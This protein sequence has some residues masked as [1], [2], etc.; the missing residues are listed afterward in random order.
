M[1][2]ATTEN[3]SDRQYIPKII[4]DLQK[5]KAQ[6]Q[7][8]TISQHPLYNIKKNLKYLEI[9]PKYYNDYLWQNSSDLSYLT[10]TN[11]VEV[12]TYLNI[13][14]YN[15]D[16]TFNMIKSEMTDITTSN[17]QY[18]IRI[19]DTLKLQNSAHVKGDDYLYVRGYCNYGIAIIEGHSDYKKLYRFL[20]YTLNA[21]KAE[22]NSTKKAGEEFNL[23]NFVQDFSSMLFDVKY[24]LS[25][26]AIE[27]MEEKNI[28]TLTKVYEFIFGTQNTSGNT[29][30]LASANFSF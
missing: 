15:K 16:F 17:Y 10:N 20:N 21:E 23:S 13:P 3:A 6:C 22:F 25:R 14:Q 18:L 19:F 4:R 27:I 1:K 2:N 29:N 11:D 12:M 24:V 9:K 8:K 7:G 5:E 30:A 28:N 26:Y